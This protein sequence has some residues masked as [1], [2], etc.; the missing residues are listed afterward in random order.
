ML[1]ELVVPFEFMYETRT[2]AIEKYFDVVNLLFSQS[3]IQPH[4]AG[5][6]PKLGNE[7]LPL[8]PRLNMWM[9]VT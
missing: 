9:F 8:T 3:K 7:T 6:K 2:S 4:L 1:F 5:E